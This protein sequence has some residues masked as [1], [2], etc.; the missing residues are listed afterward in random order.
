MKGNK[1][2]SI[3]KEFSQELFMPDEDIF[4]ELEDEPLDEVLKEVLDH[5]LLVTIENSHMAKY[6]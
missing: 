5:K 6:S 2:Q 1:L 4:P 3:I